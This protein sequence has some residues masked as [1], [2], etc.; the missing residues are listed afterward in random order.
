MRRTPSL[1]LS[2]NASGVTSKFNV[3]NRLTPE[4]EVVPNVAAPGPRKISPLVQAG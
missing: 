1:V 2:G 3:P 4:Y